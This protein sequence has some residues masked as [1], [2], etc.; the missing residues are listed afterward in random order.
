MSVTCGIERERT[1]GRGLYGVRAQQVTTPNQTVAR[2]R[3]TGGIAHRT[4]DDEPCGWREPKEL[5]AA[6]RAYAP[7]KTCHRGRRT[8]GWAPFQGSG[9]PYPISQ[10][11]AL[12]CDWIAPLGR[13]AFSTEN[14][15]ATGASQLFTQCIRAQHRQSAHRHAIAPA[16][17]AN[18]ASQPQPGA[19]PRETSRTPKTEP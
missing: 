9:H 15:S 10:G 17:S 16:P 1:V 12:G 18:G 4:W 14:R 8:R 19:P 11:A 2:R 7:R 5:R 6:E 13:L 3:P